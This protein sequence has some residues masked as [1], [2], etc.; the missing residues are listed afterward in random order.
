M[1]DVVEMILMMRNVQQFVADATKASTAV[2]KV[3]K[4]GET[5]GKKAGIGWKGLAKWAGGAAAVYGATR[6]IESAVSATEGLAKATI[7]VSRTTG[8]D[9]ETSSEWAA[10]TKERGISTTQFR[11]SLVR[12]SKQM[13]VSRTGTAKEST[14]VRDL[15]KQI[16]EVAA[17]GGKKAPAQIDKLSKAIG[18]AQASGDKARKV[19]AQLGVPLDSLQKGNTG[20][21]LYKVADALQHMH[22]ASERA[23]LMQTLFGRSGQVLLPI[24]M[25][26]SGG[27]HKL[28]EEQKA[29]GNYISGKGKKSAEDLIKQ[30]RALDTA[31]AGVKVQMGTALMPVISQVMQLLVG[32]MKLLRPLT[33]NATLFKIAIGTLAAAFVLYQ[34]AMV[35]ATIATTIFDVAAA[36]IVAIVLGVVV[37]VALLTVGIYELWKHCGWFRDIVKATWGWIKANWPLLLGILIGPVG[38]AVGLIIQH[39]DQVKKTVLAIVAAVKKAISDLVHW[40]DS[41]PGKIGHTLSKIPGVKQAGGLWHTAGGVLHRQQGGP[42]PFGRTAVVG[43]RGPE[44]ITAGT[45]LTVTPLQLDSFSGGAAGR[46]LEIIVPV[47]LDGREI[48]R[49][50]A[51]VA[52]NQLARR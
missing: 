8:M 35:A 42:V 20:E 37:A 46:A 23:T 33:K 39:F 50:T 22:R 1:A 31:M 49:S 16:D 28:L 24:L 48:A 17:A 51:R 2:E 47:L 11:M 34:I 45:G 38:L 30:Q 14:T 26:G 36:P 44:L 18:R 6:Y 5:A 32:F 41:L 3:G 21:V 52:A 9:T 27:V 4:E 10:L 12:L 25:K 40:V 13:E 29:A 43:E 19:L 7:M 15:R